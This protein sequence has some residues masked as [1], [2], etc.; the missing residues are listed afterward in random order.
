MNQTICATVVA[1]VLAAALV[2]GLVATGHT[3]NIY[4]DSP[5]SGG[6]PLIYGS[7]Q[8]YSSTYTPMQIPDLP[9]VPSITRGMGQ[10]SGPYGTAIPSG[11]SGYPCTMPGCR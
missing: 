2:L 11:P 7:Q 5:R 8:G 6:P 10:G 9:Q 4:L 1:G 3:Q